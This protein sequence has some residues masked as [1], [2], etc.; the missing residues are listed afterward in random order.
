MP[1]RTE[2]WAGGSTFGG[3]GRR[4]VPGGMYSGA[5]KKRVGEDLISRLR[6]R[7]PTSSPRTILAVLV[8]VSVAVRIAAARTLDA[9][10]IAPDEFIYALSGE[11]FWSTGSLT[12]FGAAAPFYGIYP[13]LV[14]LPIALFGNSGGLL[15]VQIVQCVLVSLTR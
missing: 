8:I 15:A 2:G 12:L 10:W 5:N 13:L 14:G 7:R 6:V 9:P 11:S 1:L 4:D 3:P